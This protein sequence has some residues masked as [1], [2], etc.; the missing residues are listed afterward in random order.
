MHAHP[1]ASQVESLGAWAYLGRGQAAARRQAFP[2]DRPYCGPPAGDV[3][4]ALVRITLRRPMRRSWQSG[5]PGETARPAA[6]RRALP[7]A[8]FDDCDATVGRGTTTLRANRRDGSRPHH[9][10]RDESQAGAHWPTRWP[11]GQ[12]DLAARARGFPVPGIGQL[13]R[14]LV[15]VT[16]TGAIVTRTTISTSAD[17]VRSRGGRARSPTLFFSAAAQS[18]SNSLPSMSCIT[19]HDSLSS[20]A[21]SRRTRTAPSATS[22]APSASSAA[23]RSSPRARYRP[24][25]QDAAGS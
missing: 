22:R 21:G 15:F 25:R 16:T 6:I 1:A 17:P 7:C 10:P 18:R 14:H 4:E 13:D 8:E 2:D 5:T 12:A 20:S 9:P 3:G 24:A 19:M 11:A 23:T